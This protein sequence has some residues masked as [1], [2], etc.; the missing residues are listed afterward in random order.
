MKYAWPMNYYLQIAAIGLTPTLKISKKEF[1]GLSNARQKLIA[2]LPIESNFDLL[3][4]NYL[5]LEQSAL[6]AASSIM[7]R[8]PSDYHEFFE[9]NAE[10]NR[11]AVNL[12]TTARLYI[13]QIRQQ[14]SACGHDP[15]SIKSAMSESY[16]KHFEYRFMEALRNHVQH[17]GTAIQSISF[18]G[19]WIPREKLERLEYA[20]SA[21]TQRS[22][23]EQDK[24]FKKSVLNECPDKIDFM[25]ASR[26]YVESLGRIHKLVRLTVKPTMD[27]A[28][29]TIESAIKRYKK[30]AKTDGIGL[31]A[32]S[33]ERGRINTKVPVMIDWDDVRVK[34]ES[35]NGD[36][37]N[38]SK[39]FVSSHSSRAN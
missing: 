14:V 34:L 7:V 32:Y 18:G 38:L 12:L 11:R 3:V 29:L 10:L 26:V 20:V 8:H 21:Y 39:S 23:L 9:I 24:T 37:T 2:G 25:N 16:D 36:L 27:L 22:S 35:R 13:D 5:E 33:S 15:Q 28:R 4:G 30:H 17:N 31:T 6:S 19:A 1:D